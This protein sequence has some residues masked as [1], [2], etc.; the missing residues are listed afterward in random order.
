VQSSTTKGYNWIINNVKKNSVYVL[1]RKAVVY[2]IR[3]DEEMAALY[4]ADAAAGNGMTDAGES[5]VHSRQLSIRF[6][7]P[8]TLMVVGLTNV[9]WEA[10]HNR[11]VGLVRAVVTSGP[12]T[13][14]E[15][16]V[17]KKTLLKAGTAA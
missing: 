10:W 1:Q 9:P 16:T 3:N 11:P 14:R 4:A 17:T 7:D 2:Y 13:G 5:R 6:A 8:T 12:Y 15:V